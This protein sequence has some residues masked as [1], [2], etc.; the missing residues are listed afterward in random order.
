MHAETATGSQ[1]QYILAYLLKY[2]KCS[3]K[4]FSKDVDNTSR[5]FFQFASH[6]LLAT[7][8]IKTTKKKKTMSARTTNVKR[9]LR[10]DTEEGKSTKCRSRDNDQRE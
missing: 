9:W 3:V 5:I 2:F 6:H 8:K 1:H 7:R 4:K 10:Q